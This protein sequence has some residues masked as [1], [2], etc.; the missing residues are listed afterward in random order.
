M[1]VA[2]R[3]DLLARYL[4]DRARLKKLEAKVKAAAEE[5]KAEVLA[6]G[7]PTP[8]GTLRLR[9]GDLV[10][11]AVRVTR[12]YPDDAAALRYEEL[13]GVELTRRAADLAKIDAARKSGKLG[14]EGYAE[15]VEERT[16]H[17]L[18][19]GQP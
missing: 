17:A 14:D 16:H 1:R 19:V 2:E 10:A 12:R 8:T 3:K 6:R 11:Q 18:R 15:L 7:K 13:S 5:I 4:R 9:V